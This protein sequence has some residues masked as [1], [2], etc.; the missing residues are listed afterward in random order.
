MMI[1]YQEGDKDLC[2][3]FW[4]YLIIGNGFSLL[5]FFFFHKY[6]AIHYNM[7]V[8]RKHKLKETNLYSRNLNPKYEEFPIF[9]SF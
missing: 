2:G 3:R 9:I 1:S 7:N 5:V 4:N 6:C 8:L